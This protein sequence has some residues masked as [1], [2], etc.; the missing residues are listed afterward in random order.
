MPNFMFNII[1]DKL[2]LNFGAKFYMCNYKIAMATFRSSQC[3][4]G[5]EVLKCS[6]DFRA[7][8]D[9]LENLNTRKST[10][11]RILPGISSKN[12]ENSEFWW[13]CSSSRLGV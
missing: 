12:F 2:L 11:R 13:G 3:Q 5:D 1:G 8:K 7:Q 6:E 4:D 10:S 9:A